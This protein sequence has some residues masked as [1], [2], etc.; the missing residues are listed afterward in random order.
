MSPPAAPSVAEVP[1]KRREAPAKRGPQP[2]T[3]TYMGES[4]TAGR[5]SVVLIDRDA[6]MHGA[7]WEFLAGIDPAEIIVPGLLGGGDVVLRA[8]GDEILTGIE[9]GVV[10]VTATSIAFGSS[11]GTSRG[12]ELLNP[13]VLKKAQAYTSG[14]QLHDP[15]SAQLIEDVI[16]FMRRLISRTGFQPA[17][18]T[19]D[20][21]G[22][23]VEAR[24]SP[25]SELLL[26]V[27]KDGTIGRR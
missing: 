12:L 18:C 4:V 23:S 27:H 19:D 8:G 20:E 15:V 17:I 1:A 2:Y 26:D 22:I 9:P 21:G 14:D 24:L 5:I 16:V 11:G 6:V 3:G 10:F 7:G 25:T 13:A